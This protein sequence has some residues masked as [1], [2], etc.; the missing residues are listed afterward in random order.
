MDIAGYKTAIK[1]W[2]EAQAGITAQWRDEQ[3]GWQS[4][5]RARLHL[6]APL[7]RGTDYTRWTQDTDLAAGVDFVPTFSGVREITLSIFVE[8]RDQ[9]G[10]G[11]AA[12][13]LEK[14]RTSLRKLSVRT[15]LRA[16]GLAHSTA[17]AVIDLDSWVD[18]RLESK[19]QLDVHFNTVVVEEDADEAASF[20]E[21]FEITPTWDP[22]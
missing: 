1:T 13:Y 11:V 16:A 6:S 22:E 15:A 12:F 7:G 19:A 3:G 17:E 4:K 21:T 18:D 10:S 20:V 9:A 2:V 8:S 5:T 14:L